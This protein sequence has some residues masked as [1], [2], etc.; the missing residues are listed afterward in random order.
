MFFKS[1][2]LNWQTL[3]YNEKVFEL[4]FS[5][6]NV[7]KSREDPIMANGQRLHSRALLISGV[8]FNIN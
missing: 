3:A 2:G 5:W 4:S 8:L 1:S 7:W 6:A